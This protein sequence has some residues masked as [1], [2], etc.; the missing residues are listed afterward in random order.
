MITF[1]D[2]TEERATALEL[3]RT[4]EFLAS[5]IESSPDAIIAARLDGTVVLFNS[6]AERILGYARA[7]VEGEASVEMLYPSGVAREIMRR[8][9]AAPERRLSGFRAEVL[10][11]DGERILALLSAALVTENGAEVATVGV[12]SD[13]RDRLRMEE[14][15][16]QWGATDAELGGEVVEVEEGAWLESAAGHL[17]AQ[18]LVDLLPEGS[19]LQCH[20]PNI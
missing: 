6:A 19:R 20:R 5:L 8:V 10:S 9:R 12:F 3:A 2:V 7:A 4:K 18:E 1:R 13:M 16:A 14:R 15:L 11:A 17:L